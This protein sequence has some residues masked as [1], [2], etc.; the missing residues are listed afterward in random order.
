MDQKPDLTS[1][2]DELRAAAASLRQMRFPAAMTATSSTAVLIGARLPLA[3]WL[4][5]T[6]R[7]AEP[8]GEINA[9]ALAV[10]RAINGSAT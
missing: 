5:E 9:T 10:A 3:D 1:P 4:D 6:A 8:F 7:Y 2:A